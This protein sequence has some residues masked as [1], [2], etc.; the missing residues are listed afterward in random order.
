MYNTRLF[1]FMNGWWK[2]KTEKSAEEE[3]EIEREHEGKFP[4]KVKEY[5]QK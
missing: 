2:W 1:Y 3:R 5:Q 4:W